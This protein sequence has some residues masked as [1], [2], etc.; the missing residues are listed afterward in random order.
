MVEAREH[1]PPRGTAG[2]PPGLD[3]PHPSSWDQASTSGLE[4]WRDGHL[5]PGG[6][7][8]HDEEVRPT[9]RDGEVIWRAAQAVI[10]KHVAPTPIIDA[11]HVTVEKAGGAA[12]SSLCV[13]E[14]Q[15]IT[16]L[17]QSG[18]THTIV[19]P[20]KP[21]AI[22]P[23]QQGLLVEAAA[24][25]APTSHRR[26]PHTARR[27]TSSSTPPAL[28][29]LARC[30]LTCTHPNAEDAPRLLLLQRPLDSPIAVTPLRADGAGA[31][32]FGTILIA[33]GPLLLTYEVGAARHT[34]WKL[35]DGVAAPP[36][37]SLAE[38]EA[39]C[40][41]G[42]AAAPIWMQPAGGAGAAAES[43]FFSQDHQLLYLLQEGRLHIHDITG[44]Q[45]LSEPCVAGAPLEQLTAASAQRVWTSFSSA[46]DDVLLVVSP[47]P[48][49]EVQLWLVSRGGT[50]PLLRASAAALVPH[51]PPPAQ[52]LK[53][54]APPAPRRRDRVRLCPRGGLG[55]GWLQLQC[56]PHDPLVAQCLE[57]LRLCVP[58]KQ[59]LLLLHATLH[60][61]VEL[62]AAP[63]AAHLRPVVPLWPQLCSALATLLAIHP[64]SPPPAPPDAF[65]RMLCSPMHGRLSP[66]APLHGLRPAA[67]PPPSAD[68]WRTSA[69]P[70]EVA[71]LRARVQVELH[72]LYEALALNQLA[73]PL[74][75]PLGELLTR[76]SA[77]VGA[78]AY[79]SHYARDFGSLRGV[80]APRGGG[81]GGGGGEARPFSMA[82]WVHATLDRRAC[83]PPPPPPRCVLLGGLRDGEGAALPPDAELWPTATAMGV[84]VA[85]YQMIAQ[86]AS[87]ASLPERMVLH[88]VERRFGLKQLEALPIGVALPLYDAIRTCRHRAP[89]DWP[90]AAYR[91]IGRDDLAKQQELLADPSAAPISLAPPPAAAR[92]ADDPDGMEAL[93]PLAAL[94]FSRDQRLAEVRRLLCS[95]RPLELR[96]GGAHEMSDHEMVDEQQQRLLLLCRRSMALP[97]GRGMFTLSSAPP[98]LTEALRHAPLSLK[99]RMQPNAATVDLDLAALPADHLVWPEFHNGAAA[100]LRL[101]PPGS[102][103]KGEGE[104]GR[105]WITYNKPHNKQHAHAGF[106]L[107]L[108]LQGHLLA[109]ANTDLYRYM[110]QG[111]DV[112]MMAVLIGMAAARRGTMHNAVAKMLCLHIPSLH[113]ATFMELELEVP[114]VVQIAALMG[115]GLLYQGSAHR[116]MTEVLLGEIARPPTNELLGCRESYSLTAGIALGMLALGCGSDAA[117]LADLHLEDKLGNYMYGKELVP[118]GPTGSHAANKAA[119]PPS[120]R[121]CRIHEGPLVNVD[122]TAAGATIAL[123][124]IFIKS[125]NASI[126]AQ[127]GVPNS[128]YM[129]HC[130]R[131]DLIML[132][133]TARN[134]IM[135]DAV[136]PT[137]EWFD[138]QLPQIRSG[139]PPLDAAVDEEALRLARVNAMAGACIALGLRFCGSNARPA[140]ELLMEKVKA[141]HAMRGAAS[142]RRAEQPTLETCVG[143]AAI[144]LSLV[145]AGSGNLDCLRL[146]RVLRR[147]VDNDVTYGYHM[148]ISMAIGFLFLGGGR[149]TLGTSNASIAALLAAIFPCFPNTPSDNRYHLQAFRHLYVLAVEARCMESLDVDTGEATLV[150][151]TVVL[152]GSGATIRK[153]TPCQLP[154]LNSIESI[155]TNSPRYWGLELQIGSNSKHKLMLRR[156]VLWVKRKAGHLAYVADP[157]GLSSIFCRQFAGARHQG[158]G[159]ASDLATAFCHEPYLL[160]FSRHLCTEQPRSGFTSARSGGGAEAEVGGT[161]TAMLRLGRA[162]SMQHTSSFC[163]AVLYECIAQE[164]AEMIPVYLELY[165]LSLTLRHTLH[166]L[167]LHSLR[168]LDC[169]YSSRL[170]HS[171]RRDLGA[172]SAEPPLQPAFVA[173]L[174]AQIRLFFSIIDFSRLGSDIP[175]CP[176]NASAARSDAVGAPFAADVSSLSL[177][178]LRSLYGASLALH[179]VTHEE[180]LVST[181]ECAPEML[182]FLVS[183]LLQSSGSSAPGASAPNAPPT[184]AL[185]N[186]A[187]VFSTAVRISSLACTPSERSPG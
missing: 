5:Q 80:G 40:H 132:R 57:V 32:D 27:L 48:A 15:A 165:H 140:C 49:A 62:A 134:L 35:C 83:A 4:I 143:A 129:L 127:F 110:S 28:G 14:A 162:A 33:S 151:L 187:S 23:V 68:D 78:A 159:S 174:S 153:V 7:R 16:M 64:P 53:Q 12:F 111:H 170:I 17:T 9:T 104:L 175:P 183:R 31:A 181:A 182:P 46:C 1:S 119:A 76:L 26:H 36:A 43:C 120:S 24:D 30:S 44:V 42:L 69:A 112:T 63:A 186:M 50:L 82:E 157:Q 22:W 126:A 52:P 51:A 133:V 87:S 37:S 184:L 146:L 160:A 67:P 92:A 60:G 173:S 79:A 178:Q 97:V 145:M 21:R 130:V 118:P 106:L 124:L 8:W 45:Q 29:A 96:M 65:T 138:A 156:R 91:L 149:L 169:Y 98:V 105:N 117:G 139:A 13:L 176:S 161:I 81:G 152:K 109:L 103:V 38:G 19:L 41:A 2:A 20:C 90:I 142:T 123:A 147:R 85:L 56:P 107:G 77:A 180:R 172:A 122:V 179:G 116:L 135:W 59:Y 185:A 72:M 166:S 163:E 89:A 93:C 10:R 115:I 71:A 75:R 177:E 74:L 54:H 25:A 47:P 158:R 137:A 73:W 39:P 3:A 11:C 167:S 125:N 131:P 61:S 148:A 128:T 155:H 168:L 66:R 121:C 101:A 164:K 171:M 136:R 150:P 144:A 70:P 114:A 34:L 18:T 88:M 86:D 113:P 154:P 141:L 102:G 100:A 58:P 55:G 84:V 108:G 94:R 99:G 95:S 6:L